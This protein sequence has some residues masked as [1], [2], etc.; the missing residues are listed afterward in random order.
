MNKIIIDG[1]NL[2]LDEII[3][4]SRKFYKVE[5]S[6]EAIERVTKNREVVDL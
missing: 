6:D 4:V 3:K 2:T 5:L 1:N